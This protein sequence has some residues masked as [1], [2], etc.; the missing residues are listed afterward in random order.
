[1]VRDTDNIL[2]FWKSKMW[3]KISREYSVQNKGV[4]N[5]HSMGRPRMKLYRI[6]IWKWGALRKQ[7]NLNA[8]KPYEAKLFWLNR[9]KETAAISPTSCIIN[10]VSKRMTD[11]V[12]TVIKQS[13]KVKTYI[14]TKI[15]KL[16]MIINIIL[17]HI[18]MI[19]TIFSMMLNWAPF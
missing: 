18:L 11:G 10:K 15:P 13:K 7:S 3:W 5:N 1:M 4:E 9:S 12:F 17:M 2:S 19:L 14:D 8:R 16:F 6:L